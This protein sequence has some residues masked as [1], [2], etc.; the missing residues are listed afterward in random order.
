MKRAID[1]I[2]TVRYV[3]RTVRLTRHY[4][5]Q[6]SST[7]SISRTHITMPLNYMRLPT[8]IS[9]PYNSFKSPILILNKFLE[10]CLRRIESDSSPSTF[11]TKRIKKCIRGL[12]NTTSQLETWKRQLSTT[13][14]DNLLPIWSVCIYLKTKCNSLSKS[15]IQ[16]VNR[17]PAFC[18]LDIWKRIIC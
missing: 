14:K 1:M 6:K 18:L 13:N 11:K 8:D 15:V 9:S 10:C 2:Y 12:V 17:K 3:S 5:F 7:G 16:I 4:K